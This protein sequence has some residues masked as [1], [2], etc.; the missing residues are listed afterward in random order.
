MSGTVLVWIDVQQGEPN[1]A[2]LQAIHAARTLAS[3]LGGDVTAITPTEGADVAARYATQVLRI[4]PPQRNQESIARALTYAMQSHGARALVMA[5]TRSAQAIL[6]RVAIRLDAA[7]LEDV[8]RLHAEANG[9]EA[10]RLVHLQRVSET[11]H[12]EAETTVIAT[13]VGAFEAAEPLAAPGTVQDLDVAYEPNDARVQVNAS[14]GSSSASVGLEETPVVVAGGRGMGSA[15]AFQTLAEPL[16]RRL[17][18]AVGATRAVVDH[19]WRPYDEQI[20]QTGKTVAP[21]LYIALGISGAVQHLSG[22]RRSRMIIAINDDADA[23]IFQTCDVG[24]V[25]DVHQVVP[26]LLDALG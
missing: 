12:V 18:G 21:D 17:G 25:G 20:G 10:D 3:D 4:E 22:M 23:A 24:I 9:I 6:P 8:T 16:A 11:L 5:A 14:E 13:K 1:L 15:E 26:A 7:Y 19:G 2:S